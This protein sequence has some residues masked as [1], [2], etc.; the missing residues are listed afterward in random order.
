MTLRLEKHWLF[1]EGHLYTVSFAWTTPSPLFTHSDLS[2][3][4]TSSETFL[5]HPAS[6]TIT[7]KLEQNLLFD[8][9]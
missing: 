8:A 1:D 5:D 7:T 2:S 6:V 9:L 4:I 3:K